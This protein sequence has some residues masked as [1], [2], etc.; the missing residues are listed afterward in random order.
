LG[1]PTAVVG[2]PDF[3]ELHVDPASIDL[4][5]PADPAGA[6]GAVQSLLAQHPRLLALVALGGARGAD[7]H[8]PEAA[9]ELRAL[10]DAVAA[11]ARVAEGALVVITSRGAAPIGEP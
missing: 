2:T 4:R 7:R 8:T 3:H 11:V 10:A 9:A 6:A 1:L 5:M